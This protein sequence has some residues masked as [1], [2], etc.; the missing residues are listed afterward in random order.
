[1]AIMTT[2]TPLIKTAN[3]AASGMRYV[4]GLRLSRPTLPRLR[5][6]FWVG[7]GL[8]GCIALI[9][10]L[11]PWITPYDP[12]E[13]LVQ[14]RMAPPS[15]AHPFGTDFF[16][17]DLFSRVLHGGQITLRI[18]F[19]AVA[20][21]GVV[22]VSLGA[23]MGLLGR[24]PERVLTQVMDAWLA[25]PGILLAVVMVA[26]FGRDEWVLLLALGISNIPA[27]YR[28]SRIETQ[29]AAS[30]E[31]IEAAIAMGA[32]QKR[33]L[34]RYILPDICPT[35]SVVLALQAARLLVAV[36]SLSFIG[37]GAAPPSPEW[38][39]LLA[40]GR[41]YMHSAWWLMVFPGLMI[42]LSVYAINLF[43]DG[44]RDWFDPRLV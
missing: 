7:G 17:R 37:L 23:L 38:G 1:M 44:L 20:I 28:L 32:G 42:A 21:A 26:A 11:A 6:K 27:V 25:L 8:I 4:R 41:Q 9:T 29:R 5:P 10:L 12:A 31:Y 18:A 22:G 30:R 39:A 34:W 13:M 24:W 36:S 40:D 16:G 15:L 3:P 14:S 19:G 33:L 35:L 2:L 43:S